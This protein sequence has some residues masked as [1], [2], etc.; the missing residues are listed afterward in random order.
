MKAG[1]Q[2]KKKIKVRAKTENLLKL[3]KK[4]FVKLSRQLPD[5]LSKRERCPTFGYLRSPYQMAL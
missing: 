2:K 3:K 5:V 1:V 4:N